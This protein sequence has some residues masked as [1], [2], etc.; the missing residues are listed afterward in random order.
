MLVV[1]DKETLIRFLSN[2]SLFSNAGL[3]VLSHLTDKINVASY[4]RGE[5]VIR[6]G[7]VGETMYLIFSGSL[8][9][10][11][12]EHQVASLEQGQFFGELSLLDSEPRSMSVS[13]LEDAVLGSISRND[14]YEV[15]KEFPSMTRDI[16][17]VLNRRLRNQNDVLI[18]EYRTREAQLTE[19]VNI[20]TAEVLRQSQ[21]IAEKNKE[22][23]DSLNYAKRLQA[24]ILPKR[25]TIAGTFPDSFILYQPKDIVSGDFYSFELQDGRE[26]IAAA[27]CTGHG[28]SGA[29]MSMIGSALLKQ[30]IAEKKITEPADILHRL[31]EGVIEALKQNEN[32]THDGMDI[33][34]CSFDLERRKLVFAGANRPLWRIRNGELQAYVSDKLPIGGLQID[35]SR[36][37]TNNYIDLEPG[38]ALYI[39]S[40]GFA[41][42]FGGESGKKL[43]TKRFKEILLSIAGRPMPEQGE[44]L[45]A[46]IKKWMGIFEQVDDLLVIGIRI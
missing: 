38:D 3:D 6:K 23:T 14:F 17:A 8:K 39:F 42:Q 35:R 32:N 46:F 7:D 15:L 12:G 33:A 28:V 34:L 41:D 29:I 11:D 4:E 25:E 31:N 40:D 43:M 13:T 30:I 19:L 18:S 2:I 45:C 22:L 24:A 37:F 27:D 20:R 36:P 10:H 1:P 9:V 26:I 21:V 44:Y 5:N 16:I